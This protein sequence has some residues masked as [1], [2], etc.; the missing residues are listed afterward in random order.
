MYI[1]N[2]DNERFRL[3]IST[4]SLVPMSKL[5]LEVISSYY[6]RKISEPIRN[7]CRNITR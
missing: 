7:L 4:I 1:K 3:S 6:V 2:C 5:N